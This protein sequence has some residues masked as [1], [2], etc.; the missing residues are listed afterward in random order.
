[1]ERFANIPFQS[2]KPALWKQL[3]SAGFV[4]EFN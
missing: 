2:K 1:M 3:H 4:I